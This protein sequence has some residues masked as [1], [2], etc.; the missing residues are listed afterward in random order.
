[1]KRFYLYNVLLL[2][3]TL[4]YCEALPLSLMR[5]CRM[6]MLR[7][8][9]VSKRV[10]LYL[11]ISICKWGFTRWQ[12]YMNMRTKKDCRLLGCYAVWLL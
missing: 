4:Y 6:R 10:E 5:I 8:I 3:V 1:M 12:W 9:F 11:F 2:P 7:N